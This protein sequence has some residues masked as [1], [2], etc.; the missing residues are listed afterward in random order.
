MTTSPVKHDARR[1][2]NISDARPTHGGTYPVWTRQA[3]ARRRLRHAR[4]HLKH[5]PL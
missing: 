4:I 2:E 1:R 3:D 5:N